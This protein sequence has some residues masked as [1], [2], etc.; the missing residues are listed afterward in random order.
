MP[1][2]QRSAALSNLASSLQLKFIEKDEWKLYTL[3]RDFKLFSIGGAKKITNMMV[4][5]DPL[6][7]TDFYIF[8]Y[9]F[10]VSTGNS[11]RRFK[12]TVFFA[13]SKSLGL[14]LFHM[15]PENFSHRIGTFFGY[16]DIDFVT[17]PKFSKK[18]HL[19]GDDEDYIRHIMNEEVLDFFTRYNR[20][21]LEGVNYYMILYKRDKLLSVK[22]IKHLYAKGIHLFE[23]FK[24][25][26][27]ENPF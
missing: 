18:Y 14:P 15:K 17:H 6:R 2:S 1:L 27:N 8:D 20:W 22:D 16:E 4:H 9:K 11:T 21:Y 24:I 12:Q 5:Y 7:H 19:K 23:L 10:T 25:E 13:N 26:N 3:L